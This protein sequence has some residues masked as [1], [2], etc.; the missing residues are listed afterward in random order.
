MFSTVAAHGRATGIIFCE[1]AMADQTTNREPCDEPCVGV[2]LLRVILLE[3]VL[4]ALLG[5]IILGVA[6]EAGFFKVGLIVAALIW[7]GVS[8]II[9][10]AT[11]RHAKRH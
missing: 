4:V 1:V 9:E 11:L 8:P 10:I 5:L 7:F 6:W 2:R 3:T